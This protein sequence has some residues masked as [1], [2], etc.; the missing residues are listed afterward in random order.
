MNG[1]PISY[2]KVIKWTF[3]NKVTFEAF[4]NPER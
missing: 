3:M 2:F 4:K 1:I